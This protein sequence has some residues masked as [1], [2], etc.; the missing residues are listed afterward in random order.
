MSLKAFH[1]FFVTVATLFCVAFGIWGVGS[2]ASHG[3]AMHLALATTSLAGAG[4]LL[5]Y[6]LWV[7]KKLKGVSYL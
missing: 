1:V 7:L 5:W 3:D 6:G 2:Y 4:L